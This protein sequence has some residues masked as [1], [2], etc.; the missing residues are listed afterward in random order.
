MHT[1]VKALDHC[2]VAGAD[3]LWWSCVHLRVVTHAGVG[4]SWPCSSL[5]LQQETPVNS[6]VYQAGLKWKGFLVISVLSGVKRPLFT[7]LPGKVAQDVVPLCCPPLSPTS[8][9][10]CSLALLMK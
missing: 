2:R 8:A 9:E 1:A 10:P 6:S 3:S 4:S 5:L 7:P